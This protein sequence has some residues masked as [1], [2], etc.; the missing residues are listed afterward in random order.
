MRTHIDWI[1]FTISMVYTDESAEAYANAIGNGIVQMFGVDLVARVFGGN[2]AKT[3]RS[4]APYTD[5]WADSERGFSLYASP[6]L[7]H[8][9]VEISG[10]G[11]ERI[12]EMGCM[13][14]IL[15][16]CAERVTRLDI[17]SD[18]ETS[19]Q[20]SEFVSIVSHERMRA[21]GMQNSETGQTCYVGS[22]KSDRYARVYRYYAPHPRAHLLRIEHVFRRKYAKSVAQ[23]ILGTS[24]NATAN[25][26]GKAFGWA[27][28]DWK[29]EE[30]EQADISIVAVE[31]KGS[32]T[33]S[34]LV[35]SVAPAVKRLIEDGTIRDPQA[36]FE[37]YFMPE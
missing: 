18:I 34:W 3:E 19:T 29:P 15:R 4:R 12:I 22:K 30:G 32:N 1:T 14:D 8:A 21:N 9:C 36:F 23:A 7:T 37:Q 35:R 31:R 26:A 24:L 13:A 25:A 6:N 2:W 20:P 27:H 33:I 28:R 11:C 10:A 5:T 16:N 17:A